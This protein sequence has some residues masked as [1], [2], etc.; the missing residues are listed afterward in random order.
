MAAVFNAKTS[1]MCGTVAAVATLLAACGGGDP[2]VDTNAQG[3]ALLGTTYASPSVTTTTSTGDAT[4]TPYTL[5][6]TEPRLPGQMLPATTTTT[7]TDVTLQ[8]LGTTTQAYV[9][10]TFALPFAPGA[11]LATDSFA[12]RLSDGTPVTLQSDIKARHPDGSVRHAIF[13]A[14]VPQLA[15]GRTRVMQLIKDS[16]P[17]TTTTATATTA[18]DLI[19]KG[20]NA[21]VEAVINGTTYQAKAEDLLK[22]TPRVWLKGNVA[23]EWLVSAPLKTASGQAHPHLSARFAIRY[24]P[25]VNRARVDM[26]VENTWAYEANPQ[27]F[28]YDVALKV[29]GAA[30]YSKTGFTHLHHARFRKLAWWG[31]APQV[32]VR[33]QPGFIIDSRAIPNFD[34]SV[35]VPETSLTSL[36]TRWA[37]AASEPMAVGLAYPGM[38][39]VGGRPD[40]GL[41][42]AWNVMWLLSQDER[43]RLTASGT[44]DLAGSWTMHYRDKNTDRPLKV[45]DYPYATI[46]GRA[47]DTLNPVT[48]KYEAFPSCPATLCKSPHGWDVP[49]MP[50]F[51]YYPYLVT[52][53]HYYLEELQFWAAL[54]AMSA[55]PAY[56]EYAKGLVKN[57]Q[58]R[59]QAWSL[60]AFGEAAYVTPDDD[61]M[62]SYFVGLVN[63]NLDWYLANYVNST[64][65][66]KLGVI[67]NGYALTYNSGRGLAPWMDDFFT[68]AVGH[69]VDLGFTKAKPLLAYKAKFP[70]DRMMGTGMCWILA[71]QY[72]MNLRDTTTTPI[73]QTIAE[74]Y[75][76][77]NDASLVSLECNGTAMSTA[78]K[79]KVGEMIGYASSEIGYPANMQPALAYAA[80]AHPQGALAWAK[81]SARTVKPNYGLGPQFAIVPR[82]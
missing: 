57:D 35:V 32:N 20:F 16:A 78:L 11:V 9:P 51:A 55:N 66:N 33:L 12:G 26:T 74:V 28:T 39:A 17:Q 76:A 64:S 1:I 19:N 41:Q 6:P 62:K 71:S 77:S 38:S 58:V 82:N 50:D 49:H 46:L 75:R 8:G 40:I 14:V 10:V 37:T 72:S 52:G 56:R 54:P 81:F 29:N 70:V 69:L 3:T 4:Q 34:R 18:A 21:S 7:L 68:S 65:A 24:Y 44:A 47:S 36:Q 48:K 80:G 59:G 42:P 27:N 53:D 15:A 67:S 79:L 5:S 13:S 73:Y 2:A 22:T 60:R 25:S 45:T 63:N 30:V 61:S 43:A 31:E 23:T